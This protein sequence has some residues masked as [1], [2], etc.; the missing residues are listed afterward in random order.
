MADILEIDYDQADQQH[1]YTN[2]INTGE[3]PLGSV[4]TPAD[5]PDAWETASLI[6]QREAVIGS[7]LRHGVNR[8][9]TSYYNYSYDRSFNPYAYWN[10]NRDQ[11]S[12]LDPF[13]RAGMFEDTMSEQHFKDRAARLLE[14]QEDMRRLQNGSGFG[15]VLGM[16]LS[17]LDISTLVPLGGQIAKGKMVYN[18][19]KIALAGG[20]LT[21]AQETILHM[22]QDL[23]TVD[24]S[25]MNIG[26]G[27]AIGGGIGVF[28]QALNPKSVLHPKNPDNPFRKD[29]QFRVGI[30]QFGKG[31]SE[32]AVIQPVVKGGKKTFEVIKESP[33]GGS[34]S[35]ATRTVGKVVKSPANRLL[36]V[37]PV[38]R[39]LLAQ[40]A[41]A[42]DFGQK[43]FDTGGVILDSMNKGEAH[44]AFEDWK[45]HYMKEFENV[46]ISGGDRYSNLRMDLEEAAGGIQSPTAQAVGDKARDAA[47]FAR[48]AVD[49]ARGNTR[50]KGEEPAD[51]KHFEAFEF[52]DLT[53][54]LLHDDLDDATV[55]NLKG[56][57]GDEGTEKIIKV[58]KEQAEDIHAVN[59]KMEDWMVES[60]MIREDQRMGR[61]YGIAQLW[62]PRAMRGTKR[63]EAVRFFMEKFLGKPSDEF[64]EEQFEMTLEQFE[65]LGRQEVKIGDEVYSIE[66]GA[67][68][69]NEILESWSGDTFDRQ[70]LQSELELK[71]AES[72]FESARRRSMQY[73][74]DL[75][76]S[77]T[78]YRKAAVEEA[79]KTLEY[80]QAERERA[81]ANRQK[82]ANEKQQIDTEIRRLEEEQNVRLNEFHD[83]GKWQRKYR[84][85]RQGQ[86]KDAE[87]LLDELEVEPGG[88][89]VADIDSARTMLTELDDDLARVNEDALNATVIEARSKPVYS[90]ALERLKERQRNLAREA[91]KID[92]RLERLN[93]RVDRLNEAVVAADEAIKHIRLLRKNIRQLR[94]EAD[95]VTR[96]QRRNV[97]KAKKSL[98]RTE[99]KLPV[100]MYVEDLVDRLGK[101][102]KIP[103]G[104]LESEVFETG[105]AKSRKIILS[106]EERRRAITLGLLRDDIYGVM[107]SAHDDVAARL[108]LRKMFGT[109]DPK[110]MIREIRDDYNSMITNAR[111]RGLTDRYIRRLEKERDKMESDIRGSW[112]RALGRYGLPEDPDSFVHWSMQK[113]RAW[114]FIK[115]GTGFLLSS[116]TDLATVSLTSGFHS[117]TWKN[118][119]QTGKMMKGLR[120]DELR[121]MALM[122]E[123]VLHNSATL[124]KSDVDDI[125]NMSGIGEHGSLKHGLTSATDRVFQGL[126]DTASVLS[127]MLW[128][129]TR[130]KALAMMEMQH[131]LVG[132]MAR[133]RQTFEAASAGNKKAQLEVAR[134]ASV[135]IGTE[136]VQ[137]IGAMMAKHPPE[138]WDGVYELEMS[139][140]LDEG[141][142]G[143]KAYDDVMFALRR[144]ATRAV[145]TPGMGET[146]LFMSKGWGKMLM[147]FQTYGFVTLNRFVVPA[148]QR[149]NP[150]TYGDMEAVMSM[151][152]AAGLG[153][154]VV[155]GKDILR[156]GEI[157]ERSPQQWAYDI[158]DRSG[159]SMFM[160]VPLASIY[161]VAGAAMGWKERPSR[162]SQQTSQLGLVFGPSGNTMTDMFGVGQNAVYGDFDAAGKSAL[163][164]APYQIFKQVGQR[165][166][167]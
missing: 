32:S 37:S 147:Q 135:G 56:R 50:P 34:V 25:F 60:G 111:Q 96:K 145:M 165:I 136:Q 120:S 166:T 38:G 121:R 66:R 13:I 43:M 160:S 149:G 67:D 144:S 167:E 112:D 104:I 88:A 129:N 47:R 130:L 74:S 41:K 3:G 28:A 134:L 71:L 102:D 93:P 137:R 85:E 113:L 159:Y 84:K 73:G 16:G 7:T 11:L 58:A 81:V 141:D 31:V 27:T 18:V 59:E 1:N 9:D 124:K 98:R 72:Q 132:Q 91:N 156:A 148:L 20:A 125:R 133:Y 153:S 65:K 107:H 12:Q 155:A 101:Q 90:R 5:D 139:R 52:Q 33:V 46:F 29:S 57:F 116:L 151:G 76:R 2:F 78:E 161:N 154:V 24:E 70:V 61:E 69:K 80:R 128:W 110:D 62:N 164:L 10:D 21:G 35:A 97:K 40:S 146:P 106:N 75:R 123:R 79:K 8:D 157:K 95:K 87:D 162:Y 4:S 36:R 142:I 126:T 109:E 131:N 127:G 89:P 163:K 152:F 108:S 103:R 54:K 49:A 114:N 17:L 45:S 77:E 30:A 122:S 64:L 22:Q 138:K 158:L 63:A 44:L 118:I 105:R 39:F 6:Y 26:I 119:S 100:H 86:V 140:W 19:G 14:E 48:E 150:M 117:Y 92:R 99:K 115:Y 143:Q 55:Q 94:K 82:V 51:G 53:Y 42:R 68:Q 83:T 15:F 23:R